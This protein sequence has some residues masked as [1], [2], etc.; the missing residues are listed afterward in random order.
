VQY[1]KIIL[2]TAGV[3][4]S[5]NS[6][7]SEYYSRVSGG[8]EVVSLSYRSHLNGNDLQELLKTN[9]EKDRALQYTSSGV[10]RDDIVLN[11]DGY[12]IRREGSQGQQKT[13][14]IA[15]KL[16]QFDFLSRVSEIKPILLLDDIF[17]KLD[18]KRVVQLVGLVALDGLGKY[19]SPI[20]TR[21]ESMRF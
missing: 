13:Y 5:V 17:D 16:A 18:F 10:H 2:Q 9:I 20:P 3:Y 11:I 4:R 1:G 7:I 6:Y 19:L 14:L 12:P 8:A 21:I 15:L